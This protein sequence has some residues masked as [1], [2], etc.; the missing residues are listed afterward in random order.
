MPTCPRHPQEN[1]IVR[2]MKRGGNFAVC[3]KCKPEPEPAAAPAPAAAPGAAV[4]PAEPTQPA[5][6][7]KKNADK[8]AWYDR[9]II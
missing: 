4:T 6:E 1:L 3:P 5:L 2:R 9:P 7:Q 8:R